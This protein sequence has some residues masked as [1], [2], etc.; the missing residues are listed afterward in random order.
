MKYFISSVL[1]IIELLLFIFSMGEIGITVEARARGITISIVNLLLVCGMI[2]ISIYSICKI[3]QR[4]KIM[5]RQFFYLLGLFD[6]WCM[7]IAIHATLMNPGKEDSDVYI[8]AGACI[9][10]GCLILLWTFISARK[11]NDKKTF[12]DGKIQSDIMEKQYF[13]YENA[14]WYYDDAF[15]EYCVVY[16][17]NST[18]RL[19]EHL[20]KLI[21]IGDLTDEEKDK[22]WDYAGIHMAY[23]LTWLASRDLLSDELN[24]TLHYPLE[25]I[26]IKE[27]TRSGLDLLRVMD[28]KITSIDIGAGEAREAFTYDPKRKRNYEMDKKDGFIH[29]FLGSYM[30]GVYPLKS[31]FFQDFEHYICQPNIR[32]CQDFSWETYDKFAK[33]MN[34]K[35]DHFVYCEEQFNIELNFEYPEEE[36]ENSNMTVYTIENDRWWLDFQVYARPDVSI[37]YKERVIESI[38]CM[39]ISLQREI[40]KQLLERYYDDYAQDFVKKRWDE[41]VTR[42]ADPVYHSPVKESLGEVMNKIS[43][44]P[45]EFFMYEELFGQLQ[46]HIYAPRDE[47]IIAYVIAGESILEEE[48]GISVCVL[49]GHVVYV[50]YGY[51]LENPWIH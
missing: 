23:L 2:G 40:S 24:E 8:G 1:I 27:H 29:K 46:L 26:D 6:I 11:S 18:D 45:E 47:N 49:D 3:K 43:K 28:Y 13:T 34:Q 39:P 15:Q 33:M 25:D 48:H 38:R 20:P 5:K 17:L 21:G 9:L 44:H 50:G 37:E 22:L 12:N 51:D 31:D 4:R 10:V 16:G 19:E 14:E 30:N 35:Y 41:E 32:Y 7:N 42:I 36:S